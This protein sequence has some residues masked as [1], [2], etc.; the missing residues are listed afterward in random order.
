MMFQPKQHTT[1]GRDLNDVDN[2]CWREPELPV[3]LSAATAAYVSP[4]VWFG[5]NGKPLISSPRPLRVSMKVDKLTPQ[6]VGLRPELY[7]LNEPYFYVRKLDDGKSPAPPAE[8]MIETMD[9]LVAKGVVPG[10]E[11]VEAAD[12]PPPADE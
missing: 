9:N 4:F 11:A 6:E 10:K 1:S 8:V 3:D 2:P 12:P 5:D 7:E